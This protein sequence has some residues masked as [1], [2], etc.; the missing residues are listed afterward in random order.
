MDRADSQ[1]GAH[2]RSIGVASPIPGRC[3]P[4][5]SWSPPS[6]CPHHDTLAD[7][8]PWRAPPNLAHDPLLLAAP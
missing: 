2:R 7:R 3:F 8:T 5:P 4:P 1:S 6:P